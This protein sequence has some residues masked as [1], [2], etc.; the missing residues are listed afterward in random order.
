M[1]SL[2][3]RPSLELRSPDSGF[4]WGFNAQH[5]GHWKLTRR[6]LGPR[7]LPQSKGQ[8]QATLK[9]AESHRR[10]FTGSRAVFFYTSTRSSVVL[11]TVFVFSHRKTK[12]VAGLK[13]GGNKSRVTRVGPLHAFCR[14]SS[15]GVLESLTPGCKCGRCSACACRD[16]LRS[17]VLCRLV[18]STSDALASR[19]SPAA[20]CTSHLLCST[21]RS[22]ATCRLGADSS[23]FAC[24]PSSSN[25]RIMATDFWGG[26]PRMFS[27]SSGLV[28]ER[29]MP[30]TGKE[31]VTHRGAVK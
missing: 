28:S 2:R 19:D 25:L 27:A 18:T 6:R 15:A 5:Q 17:T 24:S 22:G 1:G 3:T 23:P 20:R 10:S 21:D 31:R 4:C 26:K 16:S 8:G 11:V 9:F 7:W 29:G 12:Q 14:Q 30:A 13:R